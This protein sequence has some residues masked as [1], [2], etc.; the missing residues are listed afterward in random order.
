M[1]SSLAKEK[2]SSE[3]AL[4][5]LRPGGQL[6]LFLKGFEP[7][8]QQQKMTRNVVDAFNNNQIA[9]IEAGTGTGKSL[10]YLIPAVLWAHFE[11]ERT[12]ISTNTIT[13][14]EQLINK[15]I[16][17][18]LNTL[19]LDLKAVLVKG[20]SNYV[21]LRKLDDVKH[22]LPLLSPQELDEVKKI[23][24][25]KDSTQDGTRSDLSFVP[26][27]STWEKVCAESDTCTRNECPFF[28]DCHFFKARREAAEAQILVVN[29]HLLFADLA[30]RAEN[31]NYKEDAVL[32]YYDRIIIDEAHNIEEI[33]TEYFAS[34]V[35]QLQI[36]RVLGK[37]A[38]EKNSKAH[39]KLPLLKDKIIEIFKNN[40][41]SAVS[42]LL[43]RLTNDLPGV[44]RDLQTHTIEAFEAFAEFVQCLQR[45][46]SGE[47]ESPTGERKLRLLPYHQT[48][49]S[50]SSEVLVTSKKLIEALRRYVQGLYSLERDIK[51]LDHDRLNE[52]TKGI[53]SD[54]N[55]LGKRLE[56]YSVVLEN[57]VAAQP[58]PSQVRWV[59]LQSMRSLT[60]THLIDADL[61]VSNRLV[62]YL[63][64]KFST[65][66]LC[67]ATLTTNNQFD[68]FRKRLGITPVLLGSR[69]ITQNI[70][71]SPFNYRQQ[72]LLAVP[73]DIPSPL[74]PDFNKDVVEKIWH[75]IQ[76]S[77]GNAFVLFTSYKMLK[78]CYEALQK[79]LEINRYHVLKQGDDNRQSLLNKFKSTDRSVLFGTDSFWEG[80][81]VAGEALRCVIIVKLPFKVPSEPIIQAR[82]EAISARG[83]DPFMEYSLPS[84]IVKFK[85][86]FGRLIRNK[87]DRGCIICLDTRL[88]TKQYGKQF[89]NSLPECR[90]VFD[91]SN[92]IHQFMKDFY[93]STY[94]LTK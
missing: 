15:D 19:K 4:N 18:L 94:Y 22:E 44:R 49:P 77:H 42:G 64:S 21:C 60:N 32:P 68:F 92:N 93:K 57:F 17:L 40:P 24:Q 36:L 14:Q 28:K 38:A 34:R 12:V 11:K 88:I 26:S 47:G 90:Q 3:V 23:E 78:N 43:S 71:D 7:R 48:H 81:D 91:T 63:F 2:L 27:Y 62:G 20:M 30:S 82:T 75:A 86:G 54:I 84:A 51:D 74:D 31:D 52:N 58:P 41:P 50:W 16:P 37:L 67:S 39:G 35:S 56:G 79:R 13:L 59:E 73:T 61:D 46:D 80:V 33:A 87:K 53:L 1:T 29:H 83:G 70:Y 72:A 65:I 69:Q 89:L 55:A 5:I 85:Q 8:E 25:W 9:L 45:G 6:S 76:A 66:I 10:A